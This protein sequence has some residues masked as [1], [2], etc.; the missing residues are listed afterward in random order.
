MLLS[1]SKVKFQVK[2]LN[3][4]LLLGS[5]CIRDKFIPVMLSDLII[6]EIREEI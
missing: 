5:S 6:L 3:L 4:N 1:H 2:R